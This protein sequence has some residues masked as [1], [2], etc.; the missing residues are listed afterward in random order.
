MIMNTIVPNVK[1]CNL[2]LQDGFTPR[3]GNN[4]ALV[5]DRSHQRDDVNPPSS[6]RNTK[7][8]PKTGRTIG[9]IGK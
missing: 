7:A 4:A 8:S 3:L 1:L 9:V 5:S 2:P 6:R